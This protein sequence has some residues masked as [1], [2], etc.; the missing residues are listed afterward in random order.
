M[1]QYVIVTCVIISLGFCA[2]QLDA[3]ACPPNVCDSIAC[4][5]VQCG[6][7][8]LQVQGFCGCCPMCQVQLSTF[9]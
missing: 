7:N 9:K 4:E 3:I 1:K 8:E 5:P 6:P 2:A